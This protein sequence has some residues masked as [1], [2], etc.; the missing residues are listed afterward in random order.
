MSNLQAFIA[1]TLLTTALGGVTGYQIGYK[2]GKVDPMDFL[3]GQKFSAWQEGRGLIMLGPD[4][5]LAVVH[6]PS[7]EPDK[8]E[9]IK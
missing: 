4:Y 9:M 2:R 6:K 8:I 7:S 1:I 5:E 3:K